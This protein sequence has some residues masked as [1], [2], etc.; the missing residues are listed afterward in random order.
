MYWSLFDGNFEIKLEPGKEDFA[1][2][3]KGLL[4]DIRF[5]I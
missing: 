4:S 3:V 2:I 5:R 1:P